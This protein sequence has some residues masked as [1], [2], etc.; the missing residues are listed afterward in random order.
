MAL[1]YTAMS[2][3][4]KLELGALILFTKF[5]IT[6]NM[7]AF[8]MTV[9]GPLL[10]RVNVP[11]PAVGTEGDSTDIEVASNCTADGVQELPYY[12][13]D[14]LK[15]VATTLLLDVSG[16]GNKPGCWEIPTVLLTPETGSLA[17]MF[18]VLY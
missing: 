4:E 2:P 14:D 6:C 17:T 12:Y 7:G 1:V 5:A 16:A 3:A 18:S 8:E 9:T 11:T 13:D 15:R 10:A